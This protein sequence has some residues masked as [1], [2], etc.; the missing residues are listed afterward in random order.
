MQAFSRSLIEL[1]QLADQ[2]EVQDFP[3]EALGLLRRWVGFDGAVLG[4][5]E[6]AA[7]ADPDLRIT[8]AHVHGRDEGILRD[9]REVSAADPVTQAFLAGLAGPMAIDCRGLYRTRSTQ[10]LEAFSRSH[11]LRH[12]ML[13]GDPPAAG[14]AARW[15]VL[16]RSDGSAF[17][18][19]DGEYLHAAWFHLSRA[20][21]INRAA[22]LDRHD[23]VAARR[24]SALVHANGRIEVADRRFLELLRGQWPAGD[25]RQLPAEAVQWL[26]AGLSWRGARIELSAR[27]AQGFYVCTATPLQ[28]N[29]LLTPGEQAVGRRFAAG[30]SHKQIAR[31]LGVAP[32]T[33]RSQITRL[34]AKLGVHDKAALAQ[35]FLAQRPH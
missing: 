13:F 30:M 27:R 2:A 33:V 9:Y 7:D 3:R 8:Q 35:H 11:G 4:M 31:E 12:L 6:A 29:A 19:E 20:I 21:G 23:D 28:P 34:Y 15:L 26:A 25:P 10:G 1:Y 16:Y 5:G 22:L 24:S 32:N 17:A 14:E 18:A